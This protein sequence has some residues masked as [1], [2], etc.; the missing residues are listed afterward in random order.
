[1][2]VIA[3]VVEKI[4]NTVSAVMSASWP[5]QPLLARPV[6]PLQPHPHGAHHPT[7]E[8]AG[9]HPAAAVPHD[10]EPAVQDPRAA[11]DRQRRD[12]LRRHPRAVLARPAAP[13]LPRWP[14]DRVEREVAARPADHGVAVGDRGLDRPGAHEPGV[15]QEPHPAEPLAEQAQ[16][17][18]GAPQLAAIGAAPDQAQHQRHR[19]DPPPVLDHRGQAQPT[20]AAQ[21]PRPVRLGGVVVVH[22]RAGGPARDPL[23]HGVVDDHVPDRRLEQRRE[24]CQQ[25]LPDREPRPAAVLEEPVVGGPGARQ[26]GRQD[27]VGD[28]AAAGGRGAE[29]QLGEGGPGAPRHGLGEAA[30]ERGQD[31]RDGGRG[32]GSGLRGRARRGA[33]RYHPQPIAPAT[34]RA[35][36]ATPPCSPGRSRACKLQAPYGARV[37]PIHGDATRSCKII[38]SRNCDIGS[39]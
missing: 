33:P 28:V 9:R 32:H 35:A 19:P 1:M 10:L 30:D 12:P 31:R 18:A 39:E 29:Q 15:E 5:Q 37:Y 21:E 6:G 27:R 38:H 17:E 22:E 8:E 7:L 23:D 2:P 11:V 25:G 3:L 16:Q 24:H 4:A 26:P 20:L 14:R 36:P 13:P 34:A